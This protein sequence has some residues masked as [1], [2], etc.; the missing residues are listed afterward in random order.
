MDFVAIDFE[1][2]NYNHHSACSVGLAVVRTGLIESVHHFHIRPPSLNFEPRFTHIHGITPS[3]VENAPTFDKLWPQI[4]E[5]I[6][7]APV[8]ASLFPDACES[9][10]DKFL[11][12]VAHNATFD[13]SV[14]RDCLAYYNLPAPPIKYFCTCRLARHH[15]PHLPNHKLDTLSRFLKIQLN[16]HDAASDAAACAQIALYVRAKHGF[17]ALK[18]RLQPL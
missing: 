15:L 16:H 2:A 18:S 10:S 9:E 8:I 1:T 14:L 12:L 5:I 7:P 17:D 11:P 6:Q 3:M 13:M 4:C